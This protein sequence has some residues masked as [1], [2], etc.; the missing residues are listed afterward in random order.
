MNRIGQIVVIGLVG[1]VW[2]IPCFALSQQSPTQRRELGEKLFRDKVHSILE[3][4]CLGCHGDDP[5]RIRAGLD[6]RTRKGALDGGDSGPALVP[7]KAHKS[8]F[9][10]TVLRTGDVKMPPKEEERLTKNE[11]EAVKQWIDAGAPWAEPK[12]VA[13]NEWKVDPKEAWAFLP[14]NKVKVPRPKANTEWVRTPVDAFVL[15]KLQE[16]GLSPAPKADR[17]SLIRRA[18]YDLTGLPP[19]PAEVDAFL[20]DNSPNAYERLVDRLLASPHHGERWGRHWLDVVRYSDSS[21]FSNDYE[22]PN[23]WRYRDYVIR[24]FQQDKPYDRFILEQLAGDELKPSTPEGQIAV[25]YLRMGPWEHTGMSVAAVTRQLFLDD[26]TNAVGTTFLA[27]PLNCCRCH[28]HKFDP[29]PTRDYYRIQACF[30]PAQFADRKTPFLPTENTNRFAE[31]AAFVQERM[32]SNAAKLKN[33]KNADKGA[34]EEL[35]RTYRKRS[36]F[37]GLALKRY[38]PISFSVSNG[39]FGKKKKQPQTV[40]ILKGGSLASKGDAVTPGVLSAVH[41]SD[42]KRYP[43]EWNTV[44]NKSYGRRLALAKWIASEK[45]PLTARVMVNRIWHWHFGKGL[46]ATSN[47]FGKMGKRPTH[48]ELLDWMATDFVNQK[49]SIKQMHRLIML[50]STYQ[51]SDE[52]PEIKSV[53]KVDPLNESLAYFPPRRLTA[54]ELRDSILAVSGELSLTSGGPPVYPEI[55]WDVALQPRQIMGALAPIYEPSP[56]REQRHRRTI[57]TV[58]IRTVGNPFLEVFNAPNMDV[59]CERREESTVTPQ[60]FTL[61]NGQFVHEMALAMAHR[62][63]KK[64]KTRS[65]QIERAFRLVYGRTPTDRERNLCLAHYAKVCQHHQRHKPVRRDLPKQ[66]V[67]DRIAEFSGARVQIAEEWDASSYQR[68]LQPSDVSAE[69]RALAE[70][71]LVLLNSNE[72]VYLH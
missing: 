22:R 71:C 3:R 54:E 67:R 9:Y 49:W 13:K 28:D 51:Q 68:N 38:Q 56:K 21:G 61:F 33:V 4:K 69:T 43:S 39:G 16:Q 59:S 5:R 26:V 66:I 11:L 30:A 25:G 15:R 1:L 7:G 17:L 64:G 35:R 2:N 18:T 60:V 34:Q 55:N 53:R 19:T 47:N 44:P 46:V 8:L 52:H 70:I 32:K 12:A 48:P 57:Y 37:Y 29:L 65:D 10:Q 41:E 27:L 40:H 63:Q 14:V 23:A 58:Q 36:M 45:N 50:S 24:S 6:L 72:F 42:D 62:L 20:N 31:Y